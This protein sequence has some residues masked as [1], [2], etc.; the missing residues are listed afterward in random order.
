MKT[1][2]CKDND[3]VI[4]VVE[5]VGILDEIRIGVEGDSS[6]GKTVVSAHDLNAAI[7]KHLTRV[8]TNFQLE[9]NAAGLIPDALWDYEKVAKKYVKTKFKSYGR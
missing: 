7:Y 1:Y 5:I 2:K 6:C 4:D 9:L 8:L 3:V